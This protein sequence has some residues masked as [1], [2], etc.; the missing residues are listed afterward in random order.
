[1]GNKAR[2]VYVAPADQLAGRLDRLNRH[3]Q[4]V[5]AELAALENFL[6]EHPELKLP[7]ALGTGPRLVVNNTPR[8]GNDPPRAA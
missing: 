4:H 8:D 6:A 3:R 2:Y 5:A 1:M 7:A